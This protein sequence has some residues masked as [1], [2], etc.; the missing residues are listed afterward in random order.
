MIIKPHFAGP[1][2]RP[3]GNCVLR[4]SE[5]PLT[6]AT[7][8]LMCGLPGFKKW[9]GYN[10]VFRPV[11]ANVTYINEQWPAAEW[12]D[13]T[14]QHLVS[15]AAMAKQVEKTLALKTAPLPKAKAGGYQYKRLPRD[16]QRRALLLSWD[17][18][19]FALLMEQRTG[20]TKVIIDSAAYLYTLNKV[21]TLIIISINGVHRNWIDNE[22]PQDLPDYIERET[23]F[24]RGNHTKRQQA[25]FE[26]T[27]NASGKLRIFAFHFDGFSRGDKVKKMF[28][29]ALGNGSGVMVAVDE[30]TRIKNYTANRTEY[31]INAC[32]KA[33]YR[34]ILTGTQAPEGRPEELFAQYKFLSESILGYD[35]IT[36]YRA[37]FC[38]TITVNVET[39]SGNSYKSERVVAGCRNVEELRRLIE[40]HSF[41]VRR[42]E[43]MDLPPKIYKRHPI[44]M[45]PE[46]ARLYKEL[47]DEYIVEHRGQTLSAAMV[48]TR[49]LRLQQIACGWWPMA[50]DDLVSKETWRN[51]QSIFDDPEDNP[52]I[53]ALDDIIEDNPDK[54]IIWAKFR[55]D[56]EMLQKRLGPAAVSYHGGIK[57]D[58]RAANYKAFQNDPAIRYFL[59][60]EVC[61]GFGI[62]LT[63]ATMEVFYS[64]DWSLQNRL[65]AEDR[66][67]GDESKRQSTLIVDLEATGTIDTKIIRQFKSKKDLAD[68]ING[69]PKSLFLE[70]DD[71]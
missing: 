19:Y 5:K 57:D 29:Q 59:A 48:M 11:G 17:K 21:H 55:P 16:A 4:A 49:W 20:K 51:V 47:R 66:P 46:Q 37:H 43:C 52:R 34:R 45:T 31:L 42:D 2:N 40:G 35:T 58:K 7:Y 63:R 6:T 10:L 60:N 68:L 8:T 67:E 3:T 38:E 26:R 13:G 18:P 30:S 61:A 27:L 32:E 64:N 62:T 9:D 28:E 70:E 25:R 22:I 23:F 71:D 12:S 36:T 24:T 56:L 53:K 33:D 69:D 15:A 50:E 1:K 41:R 14:D 65:Q 44:E 54:M 39:P